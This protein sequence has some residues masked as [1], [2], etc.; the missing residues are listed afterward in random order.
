MGIFDQLQNVLRH[1]GSRDSLT[2]IRS[3]WA[4]T[5]LTKIIL[6]DMAGVGDATPGRADAMKVPAIVKARALL[7]LLARHPF[8]AYR[9]ADGPDAAPVSGV[10]DWLTTTKGPQS[11]QH[12]NLWSWDDVFFSGLSLWAVDRG[13]GDK[14]TD[15]LRVPPSLW[16]LD[17]GGRV[18][19]TGIPNVSAEQ[20][21]LFEG[22]QEGLLTI[23]A[24][25]IAA[26]LAMDKAWSD[27]VKHPIPMMELHSTDPNE[28]LDD[29]ERDELVAAWEAARLAGGGTAYTPAS[30]ELRTPGSVTADL[31]V[32]GRN[33][34]RLDFANFTNM[35]AALLEGSMSTAS[36]TYSTKEGSRN[37]L[38]D[39]SLG[40]WANPF[41]ARLSQDD[42]VEAGY[43]VAVDLSQLAT[44]TQPTRSPNQED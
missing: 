16:R 22:P 29:T 27:R 44:P 26:A 6:A 15:S 1:A 43:N 33:A 12:R 31:F 24:D 4:T 36:L 25:T 7:L 30:I 3:P 14:I 35:P 8:A 10:A 38:A 42:V 21:I 28:N 41:E 13:A 19:I 23:A 32:E 20:V 40:Y 34:L 17:D 5:A 18:Q 9:T 2:P 39:L 37:D 11:P